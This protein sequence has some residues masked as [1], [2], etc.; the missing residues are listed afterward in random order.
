[1]VA[2][3]LAWAVLYRLNDIWSDALAWSDGVTWLFL[4]AAVRPLAI[5][6]FGLRGAVGLFVG[7]LVTMSM[8]T[9]APT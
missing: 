2:T 4:P 1:V 5:L 8:F 3:A 9:D 6:L 7:S